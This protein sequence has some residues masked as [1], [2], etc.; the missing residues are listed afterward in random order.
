[1]E[2]AFFK[3]TQEFKLYSTENIYTID[4][5][6]SWLE[7]HDDLYEYAKLNW[8][9]GSC[10]GNLPCSHTLNNELSKFI[11]FYNALKRIVDFHEYEAYFWQELEEYQ[12]IKDNPLK[13][14]EWV[15]RNERLGSEEFVC[16][17]SSYLDYLD[18]SDTETPYHLNVFTLYFNEFDVFVDRN[19]FVN[20]IAFLEIFNKLFWEDKILPESLEAIEEEYKNLPTFEDDPSDLIK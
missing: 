1:M 17:F 13:L 11:D 10:F 12:L 18:Y 7:Q 8:N 15:K 5:I 3:A 14:K 20:T 4:Q 16:F 2:K 19:C 6:K 9:N